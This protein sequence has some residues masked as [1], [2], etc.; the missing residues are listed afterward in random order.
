M[1]MW[2]EKKKN[3]QDPTECSLLNKDMWKWS[4][5]QFSHSRVHLTPN[6]FF[7]PIFGI[8]PSPRIAYRN[9]KLSHRI[10]AVNLRTSTIQTKQRWDEKIIRR[11]EILVV[12]VPARLSVI[13]NT[14]LPNHT[15]LRR[16]LQ[17]CLDIG[18]LPCVSVI[19]HLQYE[20]RKRST[21]WL[22]ACVQYLIEADFI[23]RICNTCNNIHTSHI[24]E[25]CKHYFSRKSIFPINCRLRAFAMNID[26]MWSRAFHLCA[27]DITLIAFAYNVR[28]WI[29]YPGTIPAWDKR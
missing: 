3:R 4:E 21:A 15:Q 2:R 27:V 13:P 8:D 22:L 20:N 18:C 26:E 28:F 5:S 9:M 7:K 19:E 6:F 29:S 14:Q 1:W 11:F 12:F 23:C 24:R 17:W 16:I 25:T 10:S